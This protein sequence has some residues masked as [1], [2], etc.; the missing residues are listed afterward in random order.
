MIHNI[1]EFKVEQ[2][3]VAAAADVTA[4]AAMKIESNETEWEMTNWQVIKLL[5]SLNGL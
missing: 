5:E 2:I 3:T 1:D 4:Q